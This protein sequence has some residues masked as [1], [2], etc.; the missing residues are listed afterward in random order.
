MADGWEHL[1]AL[2][3]ESVGE[4]A[5]DGVTLSRV[6]GLIDYVDRTVLNHHEAERTLRR[7]LG[8][9]LVEEVRGLFRRTAAGEGIHNSCPSASPREK[10]RCV[11]NHLS[12]T[13]QCTPSVEWSLARAAFESA[14]SEYHAEMRRAIDRQP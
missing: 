9:G 3:L 14:V 13:V 10:V 6:I 7:L 1:D 2:A 8:S 12:A 5:S 4:A 11:Q